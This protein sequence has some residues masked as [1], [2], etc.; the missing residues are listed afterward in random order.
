MS[1][2]S[3]IH[4]GKISVFVSLIY[5]EKRNKKHIQAW[6]STAI[7]TLFFRFLVFLRR[8]QLKQLNKSNQR[9]LRA[10]VVQGK[11]EREE[12]R[13]G[14]QTSMDMHI[15]PSPLPFFFWSLWSF[16]IHP[17][18]LLFSAHGIDI[19]IQEFFSW[20][21]RSKI[22]ILIIYF[23]E[24]NIYDGFTSVFQLLWS[25]V[26]NLTDILQNYLLDVIQCVVVNTNKY[27]FNQ[28]LHIPN[29]YAPAMIS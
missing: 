13:R 28:Y 17:L 16:L 27:T 20:I 14:G 2:G 29:L 10:A 24:L 12:R 21:Y 26:L 6:S 3:F 23:T 25:K 1:N 22:S 11:T 4:G 18:P 9:G 15:A 8:E 7:N 5:S 19:L